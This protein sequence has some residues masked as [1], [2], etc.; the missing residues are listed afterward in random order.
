MSMQE[1]LNQLDKS[2]R[3][4]DFD[5]FDITVKEIASMVHDNLINV[6]PEY[7]RKFR[8]NPEAQSKLIESL[9]LGI[10]VPNLFMAANRD[11]SWEVIDGVQRISSVIHFIGD[12][13][14]LAVIGA[15][16]PLKLK[17]LDKLTAF[18]GLLFSDLPLAVQR[19]LLLKFMKI[20]TISDKS[21]FGIRF[22]LFERLNTGGVALS[23][24]EIRA[25]IYRGAF[26][27]FLTECAHN[28]NF[29]IVARI[30]KTRDKDGTSEELVLRFFA[31]LDNYQQFDHSVIDFLNSYMADATASFA[32]D[33]YGDIFE[34]TFEY[35]SEML[36]RGIVRGN[37]NKTPVNLYEGVAVGVGLALKEGRELIAMPQAKISDFINS[38]TLR[39]CTTGATNSR[40]KVAQRIEL[41]RDFV[42]SDNV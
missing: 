20:T 28:T 1:L 8:W 35:L 4:V 38:D 21:D 5:S 23:P 34:K 32:Y 13:E 11:G 30:S 15:D 3:Q 24:Q 37:G 2:K 26:N 41:S 6:A 18:N 16:K 36:P 7:Q 10:P 31:F 9:L 12:E 29:K 39:V 17:N 42:T 27:E 22:D 25:C 33:F 14:M 40:V 19:H